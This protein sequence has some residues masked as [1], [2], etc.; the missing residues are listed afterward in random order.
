MTAEQ[1]FDAKAKTALLAALESARRCTPADATGALDLIKQIKAVEVCIDH[2]QTASLKPL[3]AI[4]GKMSDQLIQSD[5]RWRAEL[6]TWIR[7]ILIFVAAELDLKPEELPK[8]EAI[9]VPAQQPSANRT[10]NMLSSTGMRSRLALV[11]GQRLG[12]ILVRM[13]YLSAADVDR[14]VKH[15]RE[16]GCQLGEA[17]IELQLM[18][19]EQLE[20]AL[21][22]QRQRRSRTNDPWMQWMQDRGDAPRSTGT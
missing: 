5:A 17:L 2:S 20:T 18:T 10:M 21:R 22:V 13:S 15:Q 1:D 4:V 8:M 3:C 11:D 14:A 12:E 9:P 16:K 6:L 7:E 19:K